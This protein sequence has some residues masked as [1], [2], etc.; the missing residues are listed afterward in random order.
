ML[1]VIATVTLKEGVRERFIEIFNRNRSFV[2]SEKGCIRYEPAID[3]DSGLP[4]QPPVR[5]DTVT[6]LET[7]EDLSDLRR[8][9]RAPHMKT[10]REETQDLV[11]GLKIQVL[12]PA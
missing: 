6:V 7:W 5:P 11:L 12:Q 10:Y 3:L 2:L 4:V 1:H 8:H 9:I